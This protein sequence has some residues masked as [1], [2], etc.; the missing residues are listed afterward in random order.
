MDSGDHL[1]S[2]VVAVAW[3]TVAAVVGF[4]V[5]RLIAAKAASSN[6][7]TISAVGRAAGALV[8]FGG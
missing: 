8:H 3:V 7:G 4:N 2:G 5:W 6:N 1:H